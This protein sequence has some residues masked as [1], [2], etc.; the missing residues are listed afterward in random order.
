MAPRGH[1]KQQAWGY[2]V[3][4]PFREVNR[5]VTFALSK[6]EFT[7]HIEFPGFHNPLKF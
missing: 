5:Q 6:L 7:G 1:M 4:R 2:R 3:A